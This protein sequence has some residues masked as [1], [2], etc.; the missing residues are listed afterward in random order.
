MIYKKISREFFNF[1]KIHQLYIE[2]FPSNERRD[3]EKML[4]LIE[5]EPRFHIVAATGQ[6]DEV[7]GFVTFWTFGFFTYV[8]H[9]VVDAAMRR[10]GIGA[11]LLNEA[12]RPGLP[13]LLEVEPPVDETTTR[14]VNFYQRL[15]LVLR[16]DIPYEQPPYSPQ[17]E[18][19]TLRL[20]VSPSMADQ[21]INT[22]AAVIR[23]E[24]FHAG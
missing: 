12:H 3:W 8:E 7:A 1:C 24:V 11:A 4:K 16:D 5:N 20:M 9:L 23:R 15:G 6:S 21:D 22:A 10:Q 14:R 19:V 2:N 17:K 13:L 18:P